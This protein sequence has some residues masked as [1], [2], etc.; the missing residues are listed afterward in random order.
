MKLPSIRRFFLT[1]AF[2]ILTGFTTAAGAASSEEWANTVLLRAIGTPGGVPVALIDVAGTPSFVTV[3]G[4]FEAGPNTY[5]SV[6]DIDIANGRLAIRDGKQVTHVL[7]LYKPRAVAFPQF[8][9][10]E[11]ESLLDAYGHHDNRPGLP[12]EVVNRW[13]GLSYEEKEKA[14]LERLNQGFVVSVAA[15]GKSAVIARL[16]DKQFTARN[17]ARREAFLNSLDPAQ[18][19]RFVGNPQPLVSL[20]QPPQALKAQVET[21]RLAGEKAASDR[22]AVL[23]ELTPEQRAL[24]EQWQGPK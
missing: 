13:P 22:A 10:A 3:A 11:V 15:A 7:M 2:A 23:A 18:R 19:K 12:I 1:A 21:S 8:S 16:F 14:L 17:K 20:K 4:Q 5:L 9:P 6:L 24:Y